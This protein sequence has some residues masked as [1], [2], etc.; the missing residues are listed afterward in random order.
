MIK[1]FRHKGLKKFFETGSRAG[2]QPHHAIRLRMQLAA[3]DTAQTIEDMEI[4]GFRLHSLKGADRGRWSIWV[5]GNWR[6]TFE[7]VDGHT[8]VLDYEDYH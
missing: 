1:S 4:P 2:I 7:F 3:L 8:Y 6:I 5:N